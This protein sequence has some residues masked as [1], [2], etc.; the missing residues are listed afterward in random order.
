LRKYLVSVALAGVALGILSAELENAAPG[1]AVVLR[2]A[3]WAML[4][5]I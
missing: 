2:Y 3:A 5:I 1:L 4:V